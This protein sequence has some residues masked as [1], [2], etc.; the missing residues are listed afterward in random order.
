MKLNR[1]CPK[2]NSTDIFIAKGKSMNQ[3]DRFMISAF[4]FITF[5]RHICT[6][7]GYIEEWVGDEKHLNVLDKKRAR[8]KDDFTDF[9]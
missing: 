1:Y 6:N 2:C 7:C 3:Y 8:S 4:K 5:D 9:V